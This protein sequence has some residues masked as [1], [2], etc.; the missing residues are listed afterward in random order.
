MSKNPSLAESQKKLNSAEF[1]E[2]VFSKSAP[3]PCPGQLARLSL[4][5]PSSNSDI[6][7][8]YLSPYINIS[9]D[10]LIPLHAPAHSFINSLVSKQYIMRLNKIRAHYGGHISLI[11]QPKKQVVK[12]FMFI[13]FRWCQPF[14]I[15]IVF[16]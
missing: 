8:R 10:Q 5:P 13:T 4:P 6:H 12:S 11:C 9:I 2:F 14:G 16:L 7:F 3:C 1:M 15:E